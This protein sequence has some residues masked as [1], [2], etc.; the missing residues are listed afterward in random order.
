MGVVGGFTWSQ[1][2]SNW[3]GSAGIGDCRGGLV[4]SREETGGR[5]SGR[6]RDRDT[7]GVGCSGSGSGW[8]LPVLVAEALRVGKPGGVG[9]LFTKVAALGIVATSQR[10]RAGGRRMKV[11]GRDI[12]SRSQQPTANSQRRAG[13]KG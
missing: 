5:D 1:R 4:V 11:S 8:T 3:R 10:M 7:S 12:A 6:D 13:G 9:R 2:W